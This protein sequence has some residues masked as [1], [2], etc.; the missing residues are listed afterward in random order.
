MTVPLRQLSILKFV[1]YV[2]SVCIRSYSVP[3]FPAFGLNTD[4][5]YAVVLCISLYIS[6]YL[7]T[8][9]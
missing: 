2:K 3:Y 5:F 4:T 8:S 9:N 1:H 6:V 7:A